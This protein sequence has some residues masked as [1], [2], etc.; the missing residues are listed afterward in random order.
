[1]IEV[2]REHGTHQLITREMDFTKPLKHIILPDNVEVA[3]ASL[4]YIKK[5]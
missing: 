1:M 2:A 3:S 5:S 4:D